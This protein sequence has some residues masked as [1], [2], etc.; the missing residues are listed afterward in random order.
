MS[1]WAAG[2]HF[3]L[4]AYP[5]Q[6]GVDASQIKVVSNEEKGYGRYRRL[7]QNSQIPRPSGYVQ[8][9]R[10][11]GEPLGA[12]PAMRRGK[13]SR[14]VKRGNLGA[15]V[16]HSL[17]DP[18][19]SRRSRRCGTLADGRRV[20]RNGPRGGAY[21]L[22]PD[23]GVGADRRRFARPRKA[24]CSR[25]SRKSEGAGRGTLRSARFLDLCPGYPSLQFLLDLAEFREKYGDRK[26]VINAYEE[27]NHVYQ[28]LREKG[29]TVVLRGRGIRGPASSSGSGSSV[30]RT[31]P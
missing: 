12:S 27:H 14:E 5:A 1:R 23:A 7:V 28:H 24:G 13:I 3:Y 22:E 15:G 6:F 17:E 8:L 4:G 30:K 9:R 25:S 19:V 18:P 31:Q 21:R 26:K 10:L 16:G 29:G 2:R 11:P 20:A